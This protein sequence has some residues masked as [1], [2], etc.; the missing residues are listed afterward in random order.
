MELLYFLVY[1]QVLLGISDLEESGLSVEYHMCHIFATLL[2][3]RFY[4]VNNNKIDY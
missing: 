3:D 4:L 1:C 2:F